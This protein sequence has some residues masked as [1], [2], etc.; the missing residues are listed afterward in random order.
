MSVLSIFHYLTVSIATAS[1]ALIALTWLEGALTIWLP[2][3]SDSRFWKF[4]D[5]VLLTLKYISMSE[6]KLS[7]ARFALNSITAEGTIQNEK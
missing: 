7:R 6:E 2:R 4:Y 1:L 3:T 5:R